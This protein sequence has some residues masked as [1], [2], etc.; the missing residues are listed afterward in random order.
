MACEHYI[1]AVFSNEL[2]Q[3]LVRV[4]RTLPVLGAPVEVA[5]QYFSAVLAA[6]VHLGLDGLGVVRID[7][8][9]LVGAGGV[10]ECVD[11][12]RRVGIHVGAVERAL[13][14][15]QPC[16]VGEGYYADFYAVDR[17]DSRAR[18]VRGLPCAYDRVEAGFL[19]HL[20][21]VDGA[22][23]LGVQHVVVGEQGR[24]YARGFHYV[25][26]QLVGRIEGR[27]ASVLAVLGEGRLEVGH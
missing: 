4:V 7:M 11:V 8:G 20:Y 16:F 9:L 3:L 10:A 1:R 18:I 27:V 26:C 24:A 15:D 12:L 14:V 23:Q 17:R 21:G 2:G 25:Q 5:D 22:L 19:K 6:P 13:A